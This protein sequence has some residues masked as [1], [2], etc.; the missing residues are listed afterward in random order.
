MHR[1]LLCHHIMSQH[2]QRECKEFRNLITDKIKKDRKEF[3]LLICPITD[4]IM[5]DPVIASDLET[6]ERAA[7]A[8]PLTVICPNNAVKKMIAD[9][10]R[11][12]VYLV[13][14]EE[15]I[16]TLIL[17]FGDT[18]HMDFTREKQ[19]GK[20]TRILC[21]I[22]CDYYWVV[23]KALKTEFD[24]RNFERV[25]V[26]RNGKRVLTNE[27]FKGSL[28]EMQRC[29][30]SVVLKLT[31][32]H[33]S[34]DKQNND[35]VYPSSESEPVVVDSS[36]E[37]ESDSSSDDDTMDESMEPEYA[38]N[39]V[40]SRLNLQQTMRQQ[41]N[42]SSDD[43][44][45]GDT[46][47]TPLSG[48]KR[49]LQTLSASNCKSSVA[50]KR[51][52]RKCRS[53]EDFSS[54]GQHL[55]KRLSKDKIDYESAKNHFLRWKKHGLEYDNTTEKWVCKKGSHKTRPQYREKCAKV[56]KSYF[57]FSDNLDNKQRFNKSTFQNVMEE[58]GFVRV[59]S[60]QGNPC[61]YGGNDWYYTNL[62]VTGE[63]L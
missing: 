62:K 19:Y 15:Y 39:N 60:E 41:F 58:R 45:M 1:H 34:L 36:S 6:Y 47:E 51:I 10:K 29:W 55:D 8:E 28:Q 57:I 21:H 43:D 12:S 4:Q 31:E 32:Q 49:P 27:F 2:S 56:W 17:K 7:I 35:F 26:I 13:Q 25:W 42:S 24:R 40:G 54:N 38:M 59:Q 61:G 23:E 9:Y 50:N 30:Q 52:R 63:P 33:H 18:K 5:I 44:T 48:Q 3:K 16:G 14:P 22:Q 37:S 20:N 11:G 46:S 53:N